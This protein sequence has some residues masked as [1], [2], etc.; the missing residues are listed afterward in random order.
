MRLQLLIL[1]TKIFTVLKIKT[2]HY[3][4]YYEG[5][6]I[7]KG[8]ETIKNNQIGYIEVILF[9]RRSTIIRNTGWEQQNLVAYIP[10]G[11]LR[12]RWVKET[13]VD[14]NSKGKSGNKKVTENKNK[15]SMNIQCC[16]GQEKDWSLH[17]SRPSRR[18]LE[19]FV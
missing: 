11:S 19:I 5:Q 10:L 13:A 9:N 15:T 14:K 17:W 16:K 6:E 1:H 18:L 4:G 2:Q 3:L 7:K 12:M 8:I